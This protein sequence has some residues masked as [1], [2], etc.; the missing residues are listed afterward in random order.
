[1]SH[2]HGKAVPALAIVI[3]AYKIDYL[4]KTLLSIAKQTCN[5]F[6]VYIG[7]DASPHHLPGIIDKYRDKFRIIYKQFDENLG[8]NDLVSHWERCIDLVGDENWIWLFSDDDIMEQTC[9]EEFYNTLQESSD[10][11]L[12]HFN[13]RQIDEN[14]KVT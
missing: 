14:D 1:M 3:P 5:E 10:F 11:D 2:Q 6:T 7:D 12:F 8:R 13:V 4:D 9:V